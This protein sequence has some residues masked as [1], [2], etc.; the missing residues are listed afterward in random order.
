MCLADHRGRLRPAPRRTFTPWITG[1][2]DHRVVGIASKGRTESLPNVYLTSAKSFPSQRKRSRGVLI[3]PPPLVP[4]KSVPKQ[5]PNRTSTPLRTRCAT[6]RRSVYPSPTVRNELRCR[7]TL[8]LL[9]QSHPGSTRSLRSQRFARVGPIRLDVEA[10]AI[11][12]WAPNRVWS[13]EVLFSGDK[14][15][16]RETTHVLHYSTSRSKREAATY[17]GDSGMS[18][19]LRVCMRNTRSFTTAFMYARRVPR[20]RTSSRCAPRKSRQILLAHLAPGRGRLGSR[21]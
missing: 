17:R 11:G 14:S 6:C 5:P 19:T 1:P 16:F 4:P 2:G 21:T 10:S 9:H 8:D 3:S 18:S 20:C 13:D 12:R 7:P 15:L